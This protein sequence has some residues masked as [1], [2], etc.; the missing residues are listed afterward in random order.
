MHFQRGSDA[1]GAKRALL[2]VRN[3]LQTLVKARL[4]WIARGIT[5]KYIDTYKTVR[6]FIIDNFK[7]APVA[8]QNIIDLFE[9]M[10]AREGRAATL[11][12]FQLELN[13]WYLRIEG[14][15]MANSIPNQTV[16]EACFVDLDGPNMREYY[17]KRK[18]DLW[19]YQPSL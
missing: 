11:R 13:E 15:L 4:R 17:V 18:G 9:I 10:E 19:R 16:D 8:T 6:P 2:I 3:T 14:K 12:A 7:T 1:H 5:L